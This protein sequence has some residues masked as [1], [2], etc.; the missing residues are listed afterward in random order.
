[1][2]KQKGKKTKRREA[3]DGKGLLDKIY[4]PQVYKACG[5]EGHNRRTCK[6]LVI[7]EGSAPG[8]GII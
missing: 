8:L 1:M 5:E 3:G 4:K 7:L 6:A 2:L